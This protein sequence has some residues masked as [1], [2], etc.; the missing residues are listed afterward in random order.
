M[1][2]V[3]WYCE[4]DISSDTHRRDIADKVGVNSGMRTQGCVVR[5]HTVSS[6]VNTNAVGI[7]STNYV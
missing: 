7:I 4:G 6:G 1:V 5:R 2:C 3:C